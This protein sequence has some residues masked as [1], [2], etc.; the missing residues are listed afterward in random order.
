MK[1][2]E[3]WHRE[4]Q[5]DIKS[6]ALGLLERVEQY[7]KLHKADTEKIL[8]LERTQIQL[9]A[10]NDKLKHVVQ[11]LEENS[12]LSNERAGKM[13]ELTLCAMQIAQKNAADDCHSLRASTAHLDQIGSNQSI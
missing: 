3:D 5:S 11:M 10:E 2:F 7:K 13:D 9:A 6:I 12:R 8:G 1:D 4:S